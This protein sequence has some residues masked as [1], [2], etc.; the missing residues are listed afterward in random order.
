MAKEA[1]TVSADGF[2]L[3]SDVIKDME[4]SKQPTEIKIGGK[5]IGLMLTLKMYDDLVKLAQ[6]NI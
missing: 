1:N 5:T 2:V 3:V 4:R 6:L